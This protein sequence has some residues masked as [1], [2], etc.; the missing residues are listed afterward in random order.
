MQCPQCGKMFAPQGLSGHLRMVHKLDKEDARQAMI[1]AAHLPDELPEGAEKG[2][3]V[4]VLVAGAGAIALGVLVAMRNRNIVACTLCGT[5]LDVSEAREAGMK[6]V[7]CFDCQG[8]VE[9]P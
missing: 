2:L 4:G 6:V 1:E 5:K 3:P 8:L 9:L 7:R